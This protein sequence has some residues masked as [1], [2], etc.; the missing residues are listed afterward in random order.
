MKEYYFV[1]NI[2]WKEN[3]VTRGLFGLEWG[4]KGRGGGPRGA[5]TF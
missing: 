1:E 5:L 4:V 3:S 2:T